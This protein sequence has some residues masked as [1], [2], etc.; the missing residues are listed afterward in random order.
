MIRYDAMTLRDYDIFICLF[1]SEYH[2][3]DIVFFRL[4]LRHFIYAAPLFTDV[5][6]YIRWHSAAITPFS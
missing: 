1:V 2:L 6:I 3:L 4:R 5:N